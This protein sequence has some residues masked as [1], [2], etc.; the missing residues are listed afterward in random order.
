MTSDYSKTGFYTVT[1]QVD[2]EFSNTTRTISFN[3][4]VTCVHSILTA[5]TISNQLYYIGDPQKTLA[6]PTYTLTPNGCPI[7]LNYS[8]TQTDGSALPNAIKLD[9]A[10]FGSEVIKIYETDTMAAKIYQIKVIAT[11]KKTLITSDTLTF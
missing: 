11:D 6:I 7:E 3:L 10:N 2:E 5:S 4:L 9:A 1:L 8:V